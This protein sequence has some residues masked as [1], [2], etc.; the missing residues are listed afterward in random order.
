MIDVSHDH[1]CQALPLQTF[2]TFLQM[3]SLKGRIDF[4]CF[5]ICFIGRL[6]YDFVFGWTFNS[7]TCLFSSAVHGMGRKLNGSLDKHFLTPTGVV[8]PAHCRLIFTLYSVYG[9]FARHGYK[10]AA[11]IHA[12]VLGTYTIRNCLFDDG[13]IA[14]VICNLLNNFKS[15]NFL[16]SLSKCN[17]F[18]MYRF[19]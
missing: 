7:L 13:K 2:Y 10:S 17:S 14:I 1:A 12:E 11:G 5:P 15:F 4:V 3:S 18:R 16:L 6:T 19:Y 9:L 8:W